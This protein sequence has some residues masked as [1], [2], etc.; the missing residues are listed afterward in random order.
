MPSTSAPIA[1]TNALQFMR[2]IGQLKTLKRTGWVN[3]D[4]MLPESVADHM[5]RMAVIAMLLTDD[6]LDK[7]RLVKSE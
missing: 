6:R 1:P 2:V 3:N 5:Y 7:N 4:V